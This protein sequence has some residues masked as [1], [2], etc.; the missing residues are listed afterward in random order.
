MI[1]YNSRIMPLHRSRRAK[2]GTVVVI[3]GYAVAA[4][5]IVVFCAVLSQL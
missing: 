1:A 4:V 3:A 5:A 2:I